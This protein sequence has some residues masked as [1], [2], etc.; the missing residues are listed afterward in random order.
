M[1]VSLVLISLGA[2]IMTATLAALTVTIPFLI[3]VNR[4][5]WPLSANAAAFVTVYY[6]LILTLG[7]VGFGRDFTSMWD[8]HEQW[9]LRVFDIPAEEYLW[10][11]LFPAAYALVIAWV[12]DVR[13][14]P[15]QAI[16]KS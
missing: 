2:G 4:D 10:S 12:A 8:G 1:S 3:A 9:G 6:W 13:V 14:V 15:R 11:I 16:R 7:S 5:H